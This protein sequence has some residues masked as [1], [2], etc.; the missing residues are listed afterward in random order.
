[1]A[2]CCPETSDP[3][4]FPRAP[5]ASEVRPGPFAARRS[6]MACEHRWGPG[7]FANHAQGAP[8]QVRPVL[9]RGTQRRRYEDRRVDL[10]PVRRRELH[11]SA[12]LSQ[13]HHAAVR[14]RGMKQVVRVVTKRTPITLQPEAPTE[15]RQDP[16]L[17]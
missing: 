14:L 6:R 7:G 11:A 2:R 13:Q 8:S 17:D 16:A 12:H 15:N 10:S 5:R 9:K 4:N 3:D 1:M